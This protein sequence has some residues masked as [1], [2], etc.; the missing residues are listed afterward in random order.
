MGVVH[1]ERAIGVEQPLDNLR[2]GSVEVDHSGCVVYTRGAV[3][4][5]GARESG[6]S[7]CGSFLSSNSG[8]AR[9]RSPVSPLSFNV[10]RGPQ[11][12]QPDRRCCQNQK[13]ALVCPTEDGPYATVAIFRHKFR[14]RRNLVLVGSTG[15]MLLS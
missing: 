1:I 10:Y 2:L 14:Q 9:S 15:M 5:E 3:V 4:N 8:R 12:L 6:G 11:R 7:F 13:S